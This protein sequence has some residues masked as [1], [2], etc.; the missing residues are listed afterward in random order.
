ML[1]PPKAVPCVEYVLP[2]AL[3]GGSGA[4]RR[5]RDAVV[6]YAAEVPEAPRVVHGLQPGAVL[7]RGG[8][9][10]LLVLGRV[11]C[12]PSQLARVEAWRV[13]G[14]RGKVGLTNRWAVGGGG[15]ERGGGVR[16]LC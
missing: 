13:E 11:P 2:A 16:R 6:A 15:Q 9:V 5:P 8:H 14:T 1:G 7:G 10:P 3:V 12:V 4:A